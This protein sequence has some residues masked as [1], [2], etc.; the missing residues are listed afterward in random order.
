MADAVLGNRRLPVGSIGRHASGW[1]GMLCVIATEAALFGYLLFS[2]YFFVIQATA[3]WPPDGMPRLRIALPNTAILIASSVAMWWGERGI[4]RGRVVR[5]WIGLAIAIVLGA[6]FIGL[7]ILEWHNRPFTLS[8]NSY[9]SLYF[10]TT[11]FHLAH[12]LVGL[13]TLAVLLVWSVL[14]YFGSDRHAPVS[15][16][17][18]Y[19]HFVDVVWLFVFGTYYMTPYLGLAHGA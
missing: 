7:Q 8:S 4:K 11:G 19:W 3:P 18:T 17:A 13:V 16:G 6:I 9:G 5:L 15:I 12:V 10:T 1:W 14:G 2:Y